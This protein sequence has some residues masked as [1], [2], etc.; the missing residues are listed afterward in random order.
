VAVREQATICDAAPQAV[1]AGVGPPPTGGGGGGIWGDA[2][3]TARR[4]FDTAADWVASL[5]F[6]VGPQA[7]A[8]THTNDMMCCKK[9]AK[10]ERVFG[11]KLAKMNPAD[12]GEGGVS[13]FIPSRCLHRA[14]LHLVAANMVK[15][16]THCACVSCA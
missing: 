13:F 2:G 9:E 8:T 3:V 5:Y 16:L 14:F 4:W 6:G 15:V 10:V 7:T 12:L 1:G 11:T